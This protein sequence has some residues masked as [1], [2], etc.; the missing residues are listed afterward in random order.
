MIINSFI[1]TSERHGKCRAF[2]D[3]EE[4]IA[5]DARQL[6]FSDDGDRPLPEANRQ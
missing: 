2:R 3:V 6:A 5:V 4:N 1:W